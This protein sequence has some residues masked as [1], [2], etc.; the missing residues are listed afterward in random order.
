MDRPVACVAGTGLDAAA[1]QRFCHETLSPWQ[2][3]R[4]VW[5]V[6]EIPADERGKI[7]RRALAARFAAKP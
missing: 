2:V 4:V 6:A 1:V 5:I 3:P 7:S